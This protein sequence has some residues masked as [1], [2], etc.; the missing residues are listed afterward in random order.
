LR[1]FERENH[2]WGI[3]GE[4]RPGTRTVPASAG[5]GYE[6]LFLLED[7]DWYDSHY[8][9]W[10]AVHG[11]RLEGFTLIGNTGGGTGIA[12]GNLLHSAFVDLDVRGFDCAIGPIKTAVSYPITGARL[13]LDGT[14]CP[15]AFN[16][17]IAHLTDL[18]LGR[19]G[20][21]YLYFA[22]SGGSVANAFA[23]DPD[24]GQ[25]EHYWVVVN[26]DD[27]GALALANVGVDQETSTPGL[28]S[29][30]RV[31]AFRRGGFDLTYRDTRL[32]LPRVQL[33]AFVLNGPAGAAGAAAPPCRLML[34]G[35]TIDRGRC[36]ADVYSPRWRVGKPSDFGPG[37][38]WA[39][40]PPA[41]TGG[42]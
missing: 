26:A 31:D 5:Y 12:V 10:Q 34:D 42:R 29:A 22:G 19:G 20:Y 40:A 18:S 23:A 7:R 3:L 25:M 11:V 13:D 32:N 38:P 37:V 33:P 35:V 14:F 9:P 15:V 1:Y 28:K 16:G 27:P 2:C 4:R 41:A 39:A 24:H 6:D 8:S 36:V 17:T 30:G 21:C